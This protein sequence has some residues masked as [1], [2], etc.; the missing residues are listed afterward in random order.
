[1]ASKAVLKAHAGE[2][3]ASRCKPLLAVK[4]LMLNIVKVGRSGKVQTFLAR[5]I[6]MRIGNSRF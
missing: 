5:L 6:G 3:T 4:P 2:N 1:M